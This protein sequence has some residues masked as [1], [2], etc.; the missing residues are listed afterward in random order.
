MLQRV[1]QFVAFV[2]LLVSF[3]TLG[4]LA[5]CDELS[6]DS[7]EGEIGD[8][9]V[10]FGA[11]SG[12]SVQVTSA[13][14][15]K[16]CGEQSLKLTY[17]LQPSSYMFCARGYGLDV[18]GAH[19]EADEPQKIE[20]SQYQGISVAMNGKD[21]GPVAFDVKDSGGEMWRFMIDNNT[22]E[23]WVT[24]EIPFS[25]LTARDDWQPANADGNLKLDFPIKSFQFEPK[26][27]GQG[28]VYFDCVHLIPNE[29]SGQ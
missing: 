28:T 13:K 22:Q 2:F 14:D 8:K 5:F 4:R 1:N 9:T 20:W 26:Q 17:D 3:F 12:S 18:A 16:Q 21:L 23:G 7:F 10:D 19:W 11:G 24:I 15:M 27:P 25:K 29:P 6:L